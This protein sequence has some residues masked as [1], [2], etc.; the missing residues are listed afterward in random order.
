MQSKNRVQ[1]IGYLGK[2]PDMQYLPSG[3][4]VA[5]F[6]IA[7]SER[8]KDGKTATEWHNIVAFTKMAEICSKFLQKGSLVWVEGRLQTR[9][10]EDK[11]GGKHSITEI[12]LSSMQML[13]KKKSNTEEDVPPGDDVP[14]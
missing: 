2:D 6:S 7:T 9:H 5:K 3:T 8:K 11:S 4:A 10:W 14:F 13:D 12:I 1:L